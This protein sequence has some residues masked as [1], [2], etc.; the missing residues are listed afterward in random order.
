M[1]LIS[2]D[3]KENVALDN[4]IYRILYADTTV[5]GLVSNKIYKTR[6]PQDVVMPCIVYQIIS[7]NPEDTK[8]LTGDVDRVRVQVTAISE[9]YA[10]AR[11]II[12]AVKAAL[13]R[14]SGTVDGTIID[15]MTYDNMGDLYNDELHMQFIDFIV[16]VK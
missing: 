3:T 16:R 4:A 10:G 2:E 6:V 5:Q 8:D 15:S 1:R 7:S 11:G 13:N 12:V 9:S 14:Y